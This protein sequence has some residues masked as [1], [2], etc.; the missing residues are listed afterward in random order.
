M[1]P[2]EYE[3]ELQRMAEAEAAAESEAAAAIASGDEARIRE[4][5][6][7]ISTERWL[8][9]VL[10]APNVSLETLRE[11]ERIG[12]DYYPMSSWI[13][14]RRR[15]VERQQSYSTS[16]SFGSSTYASNLS[17]YTADWYD[18]A[19]YSAMKFNTWE[20]DM[21]DAISTIRSSSYDSY[22]NSYS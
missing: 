22:R 14:S 15:E 8:E 5:L 9:Y 18:S 10:D 17:T 2:A 19:E 16:T 12:E 7:A 1:T 20:R 3:A 4:A 21:S 11:A 6:T 13:A